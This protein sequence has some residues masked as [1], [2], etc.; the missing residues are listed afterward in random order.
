[1][2]TNEA[3]ASLRSRDIPKS[4]RVR[5]VKAAPAGTCT[6]IAQANDDGNPKKS[7]EIPAKGFN[8]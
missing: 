3:T 2:K 8:K 1:M 7:F 5:E 4:E 6:K